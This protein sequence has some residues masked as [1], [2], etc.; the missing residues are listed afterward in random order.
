MSHGRARDE[1]KEMQ[2]RPLA[3]RRDAHGGRYFSGPWDLTRN[4]DVCLPIIPR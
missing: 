3:P 4:S 2:D 1:R